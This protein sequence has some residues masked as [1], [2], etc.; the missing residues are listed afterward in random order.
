MQVESKVAPMRFSST[1]FLAAAFFITAPAAAQ[2]TTYST[3]GTAVQSG[4]DCVELTSG[5]GGTSGAVWADQVLD[6]TQPFHIQARVNLGSINHGAEG[7]VLVFHTEGPNTS[8]TAYS[9]FNTSFGVELDTRYQPENGDIEADHIAL[10]NDGSFVHTDSPGTNTAGPVAAFVDAGDLEDGEDHF[11]DVLWDPSGPQMSVHLDCVERLVG[12]VDLVDDIFHGE[13]FVTWGFAADASDAYNIPRVCVTGNATG[14]DTQIYACPESAVQLVAGGLDVTEY[15]WSPSNAVSD[16]TLQ[17]PMYTGVVSNTLTVTYTNQCGLQIT[18]D[19]EIVVEE[20]AVELASEGNT[21]NCTNSEVLVCEASSAFGTYLEYGWYVNNAWVAEGTTFSMDSPGTLTLRATYPGTTS[22]MCEDEV[23]MQVT[24]DTLRFDVD[25]GLPGVVTCLN[26]T[27][28]LLG[29]CTDHPAVSVQWTTEDGTFAGSTEGTEAYAAAGGTYTLAATN[30]N[31]GCTSYDSVTVA[32]DMETPEVTLGY[33]TGILDCDVNSVS[34]VGLDVFPQEYTPLYTWMN[35]A[36]GDV[37]STESEPEFEQAGTYTLLVE[38]LENGCTTT[39]KEAAEVDSNAEIL[40]LS[41]LVLP[42]VI[43]PD[44][45]GSNDRFIPF[46]PGHEDT[47]VLTMLDEYR[48]QVYNR[49]GT[50]LFE[51][52]GQPLQWDGRANGS[53]VDPGSY[54]VSVSYFA[55]CGG[56]QSGELRTTLEVIR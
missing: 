23:N 55:T 37:V 17:A 7:V 12:S 56:E 53:L 14:T 10:I 49:W 41:Q 15:L 32:E 26:P 44:D 38:F 39:V 25:A 33:V 18:D 13:R 9:D 29:S 11:V 8:G 51:N 6:L 27:L 3:H 5:N 46:V 2:L 16:P 31:N 52:N 30:T 42:N 34:A 40:D 45:N 19:V 43:T 35:A 47:N 1:P 50:L 48:I 28:E 36:T 24:V 20:V 21:L 54:I 22:L 4:E